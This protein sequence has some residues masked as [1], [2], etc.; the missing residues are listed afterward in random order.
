GEGG[1]AARHQLAVDDRDGE[2]NAIRRAGV[3]PPSSVRPRVGGDPVSREIGV[4]ELSAPLPRGQTEDCE[5]VQHRREVPISQS[6]AVTLTLVPAFTLARAFTSP[7]PW[8]QAC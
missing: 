2:F 3:D 4:F 1:P 5:A 6:T 8:A 7:C